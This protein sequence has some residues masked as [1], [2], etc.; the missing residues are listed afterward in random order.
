M[1]EPDARLYPQRPILAA[2]IALVRDGRTLV[3]RRARAPLAGVYSF[4]GG[5]VELG[6]TVRE[7]ALRELR[8][9]TGLEADIVG[10]LDHVESIVREGE[11]VRAHYAIVAFVARWRG[12]EPQPGP[13]LD[14]F[15]WVNA[16]EVVHYRTTPE[17]PRLIE[18]AIRL[19]MA[20]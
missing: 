7:A 9:E 8:E 14:S 20:E 15:A 1:S 3:A 13:E 18:R 16:A 11:R 5:G 19:A 12:G 17:L 2:S 10:F 4:P 6:E